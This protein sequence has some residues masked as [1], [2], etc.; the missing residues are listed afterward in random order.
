M[1]SYFF[2][3][4]LSEDKK[5]ISSKI[6][7]AATIL[8]VWLRCL[9]DLRN[10]CAHYSRLYYWIFPAIPIFPKSSKIVA[11]RSLF[12]QI[13][14]LKYLYPQK[15]LWK[16]NFVRPL[17]NLIEKYAIDV[18]LKHIGFPKSWEQILLN[19]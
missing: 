5:I 2:K 9:T 8:D 1:L 4:L 13:L 7:T 3:D 14:V 11:D 18:S 10:R 19:E 6:G 16:E 15:S 12:Y 17:K